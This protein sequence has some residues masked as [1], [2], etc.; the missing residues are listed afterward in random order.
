MPNAPNWFEIPAT[1][2][3]RAKFYGSL[4]GTEIA[5]GEGSPGNKLA[6]FPAEDGV[7]G[8]LV[9]GESYSPTTEGS[10]VYLSAGNDSAAVLGRVE[11]A[12][13]KILLPRT[14]IG[15]HGFVAFVLDT[16]GNRV[17]LHGMG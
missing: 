6:M 15:E 16:E 17:G 11:K 10:I 13:G 5:V 1:D 2:I 3:E 7:G 9:K 8:A 12:G 4:L 14:D